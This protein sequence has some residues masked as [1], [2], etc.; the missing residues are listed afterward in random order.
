MTATAFAAC[1]AAPGETL[2]PGQDVKGRLWD[3]LMVLKY[4]I[5]NSSGPSN[6]VQFTVSVWDGQRHLDVK[7]KSVCGPDDDG[8][9]C[10]TIMLPDED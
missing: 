10:L 5:R 8:A 7:L 9:P 6:L 2:P 4:A 3:V 1:V